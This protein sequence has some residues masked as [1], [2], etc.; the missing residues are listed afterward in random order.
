MQAKPKSQKLWDYT[1][2]NLCGLG[3]FLFPAESVI[4]KNWEGIL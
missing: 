1:S 4:I 2:L 3:F